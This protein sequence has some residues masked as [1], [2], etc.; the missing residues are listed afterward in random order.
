M[1]RNYFMISI[2][3]AIAGA[4]M[5]FAAVGGERSSGIE[6]WTAI[7]ESVAASLQDVP[8]VNDTGQ[9]N[10][11]AIVTE[12]ESDKTAIA[13]PA[14]PAAD[15]NGLISINSAGLT[16]LQEIPGIG[17]KKAQAILDYRNQHG[18]F[19]SIHDL[20]SIKGIGNKMLEKMKPYIEL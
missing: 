14:L 7:N 15:S 4:G 6:G 20:T 12:T 18:A 10:A 2:I 3:S 17:E 16:E 19:Q 8:S 11:D 13:S 9:K 1:K 5:M